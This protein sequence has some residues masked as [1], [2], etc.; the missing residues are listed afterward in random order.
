M[1]AHG[2]NPTNDGFNNKVGVG[3]GGGRYL[4]QK[5]NKNAREM[6]LNVVGIED[7]EALFQ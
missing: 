2:H 7:R 4:K 3:G 5:N 1:L 6:K